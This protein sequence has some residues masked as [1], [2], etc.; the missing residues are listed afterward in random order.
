MAFL[1][2][3]CSFDADSSFVTQ[4]IKLHLRQMKPDQTDFHDLVSGYKA[5]ETNY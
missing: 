3:V 4:L 2:Q 5:D 1:T